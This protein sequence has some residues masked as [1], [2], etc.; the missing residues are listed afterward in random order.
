MRRVFR[1]AAR[2]PRIN[3]VVL[4]QGPYDV[5]PMVLKGLTNPRS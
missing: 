3:F 5:E 1:Q 4:G 2:T